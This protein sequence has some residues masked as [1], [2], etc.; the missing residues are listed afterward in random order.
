[1]DKKL[2]VVILFWND[3]KKTIKCLESLF[4]Q[5]K[6][7]LSIVLVDNNSDRKFTNNIFR[8]FEMN[9]IHKI[10]VESNS[11]IKNDNKNKRYC[12]YIRNKINYGCGLGHNSGYAFCLK[13]NFK[14]ISRI[15]NDMIAPSDLMNNLVNR[16]DQ[17]NDIIALSPKVMFNHERNKIWFG[18][19]KIGNNLKFQ[20]QCSN[21]ICGQIDN[22][23]FKG[24]ID[25]DAIVGCASIM[26]SKNLSNAG[27]SD[28]DFFYGEEDIELSYRLKKTKGKIVVDL[29]QKI[30]HAVSHTVGS[31]WAKNIYYNYKYRLLLVKKIGSWSDKLLGYSV[32]LFK[33]SLMIILSFN[34]K[35]SS[36]LTPTFLAGLHFY[37]GKYGDY[38]RRNYLK[39]NKFFLMFNKKTSLIDI[40]KLCM[41]NK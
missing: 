12:F 7:K 26:R 6:Q 16:L 15:D 32:F 29:D 28:P 27:L 9:N 3:D 14:Y 39:I 18:G 5:K 30:Y 23:K 40:F 2:A 38:D 37:Y 36:R 10:E 31:N 8:W 22:Q 21:Y 1:M 35:Y 25:T 20:R 19:A 24:L 17:N 33:F 41:K 13:N 11:V 34:L 4:N